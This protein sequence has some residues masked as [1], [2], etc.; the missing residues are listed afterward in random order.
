MSYFR[1]FI[2]GAAGA[3]AMV[4]G[5]A[6]VSAE[7]TLGEALGPTPD[8]RG[9][10]VNIV[11]AD[12]VNGSYCTYRDSESPDCVRASNYQG[13]VRNPV[14]T[15]E[16]VNRGSC[17]FR[18]PDS[19]GCSQAPRYARVPSL[20][21]A[22]ASMEKGVAT[23]ER[24]KPM[25]KAEMAKPMAKPAEV[26]DPPGLATAERPHQHAQPAAV[27][28]AGEPRSAASGLDQRKRPPA[29]QPVR[30]AASAPTIAT[31]EQDR[32]KVVDT[33]GEL[34]GRTAEAIHELGRI[35]REL[36]NMRTAMDKEG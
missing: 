14:L 15:A 26:A 13:G 24:T 31:L 28:G 23:A 35:D 30:Y 33:L 5:A 10:T 22:R 6:M 12:Y 16:F 3:L 8:V 2:I 9:V 1:K 34:V 29:V 19:A 25:A 11:T 32:E 7:S 20:A 18:T 17:T 27:G 21:E 36:I 4:G